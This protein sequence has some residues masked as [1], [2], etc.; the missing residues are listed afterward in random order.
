MAGFQLQAALKFMQQVLPKQQNQIQDIVSQIE[1][2][3][4]FGQAIMAHVATD[5]A[6]QLQLAETHGSLSDAIIAVATTLRLQVQQLGQLKRLLQY[7]LFLLIMLGGMAIA[8]RTYLLPELATWQNNLQAT[9]GRP[10]SFYVLC[11]VGGIL[12]LTAAGLGVQWYRKCSPLQRIMWLM[13][14]PVVRGL[15]RQHQG[16]Q[17]S[18]NLSLLMQSG[19]SIQQVSQLYVAQPEQSFLAEFGQLMQAHLAQGYDVPS[20]I[21]KVTFLPDELALF[22]VRGKTNAQIALD[23]RAYSQIAFQRLTTT[24]NRL[25]GI[26]QPILFTLIAVAIVAIYASML[27]PMYKLMGNMS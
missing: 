19:H 27:L 21:Q 4:A 13:R 25:L 18:Q 6:L 24:Y 26:V 1:S 12:L 16:Y 5:I 2:G 23:L 17:F 3:Q 14:I 7:P 20:F 22:F 11:G 8:I 9:N 15:I 10:W